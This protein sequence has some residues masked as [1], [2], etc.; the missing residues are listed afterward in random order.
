M[1]FP[2]FILGGQRHLTLKQAQWSNWPSGPVVQLTQWSNW[3][4][5]PVAQWSNWPSGPVS[6][7][8]SQSAFIICDI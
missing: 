7:H 1:K 8:S 2:I 6:C 3:P 5:A 4:S